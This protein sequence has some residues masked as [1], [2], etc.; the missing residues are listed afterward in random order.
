MTMPETAAAPCAA[1][2]QLRAAE[3]IMEQQETDAWTNEKRIA[4]DSWLAQSPA[5]VLAYW[6][7][8]AAWGRTHRLA[9]LRQKQSM[10]TESGRSRSKW[11]AILGSVAGA[12]IVAALGTQL[13]SSRLYAPAITYST[14]VGGHRTLALA[15]GSRI[16]LNTDTMLRVRGQQRSVE[17]VQGEAYFQIKHDSLNPFVV[18]VAGHRI[19]DL[20]TKFLIR[21]DRGRL[22]VTLL[23]GSVRFESADPSVQT[24]SEML[25]PGDVAIATDHSVSVTRKATQ[26][27]ADVSAWRTGMLVFRDT[28]LADAV[29]ELNRYNRRKF[30]IAD[31]HVADVKIDGEFRT[32]NVAGFM[33]MAEHVLD[34]HMQSRGDKIA[35]SR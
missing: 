27:L 32:D 10:A 7:L 35:I 8:K 28:A 23:D 13:A 25:K 30:V 14:P 16:E 34:L 9:A 6:R 2:V 33:N 19:T 24:H 12:V 29:T 15:D 18:K 4:L 26:M 5:H 1:D 22:V 20:G 11:L 21:N 17:L 3:W 31:P